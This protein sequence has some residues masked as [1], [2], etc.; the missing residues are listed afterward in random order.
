MWKVEYSESAAKELRKLDKKQA[1]TI[2]DWID[3][4]SQSAADPKLFAEQ[5]TGNLSEFWRFRI[6]DFRVVWKLNDDVVTILVL[7]IAH[8]R[9]VYRTDI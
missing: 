6:G 3:K 7:R 5:L 8:R 4:R 9:E 2:L 1:K